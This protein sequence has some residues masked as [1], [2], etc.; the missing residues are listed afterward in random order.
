MPSLCLEKRGIDISGK[1]TVTAFDLLKRGRYYNYVMTVCDEASAERCPVFPRSLE[2]LH[3]GFRDPS[4]FEGTDEEVM[5]Q[6][7]AVRDGIKEKII[8]WI[9][10]VGR[11]SKKS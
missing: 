11:E 1:K 8:E 9:S 2:R 4:K 3:W 5:E 7:R 6:V 10:T